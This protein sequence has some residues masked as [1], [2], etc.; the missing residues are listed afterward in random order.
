MPAEIG[1]LKSLVCLDVSE[2][3]L[4]DLPDE[5]GGLQ[6]L[7]D[8]HLSQNMIEKLP[9]GIGQLH[10]LTILKID[11]NRLSSLNANIGKYVFE[12]TFYLNYNLDVQ[13][14]TY[15]VFFFRCESL[16]ELILT[17]NYLLE[18]PTTMGNLLNLNNLN[19]DRNGL[20]S[21]PTEIGN[22]AIL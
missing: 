8:L 10:K 1:Q 13:F 3:H 6:S 5:I 15:T 19:V 17:E 14:I 12:F 9:D 18:L 2:N 16:Q 4:E 11:Q 22:F 7:T 20:Q 21:L